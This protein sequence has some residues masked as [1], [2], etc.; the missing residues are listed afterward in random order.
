MTSLLV[1]Q[2]SSHKKVILPI[3]HGI[4]KTS[5][6]NKYFQLAM[7]KFKYF[8]NNSVKEMAKAIL[9]ELSKRNED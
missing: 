1:R 5:L 9:I 3:L 4:T 8:K 2:N 6:E 7:I